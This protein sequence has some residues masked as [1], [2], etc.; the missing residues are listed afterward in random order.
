M[1]FLADAPPLLRFEISRD[2]ALL[3]ERED[4]VWTDFKVRAMVDWWDWAPYARM[5]AAAARGESPDLTY[6]SD[7]GWLLWSGG[8]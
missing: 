6:L 5:F 3:L 2:G 1:I 4:G 8:R 7:G